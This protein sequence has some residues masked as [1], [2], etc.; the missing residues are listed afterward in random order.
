M[1][2]DMDSEPSTA[3]AQSSYFSGCMASPAW[4]PQ[5]VRRSPARFQLLARGGGGDDAAGRGGRRA[6]RGLLRRLVR[7]SKSICSNACRAPAAAA[8]FKYDADSYAKNFD[9]GRWHPCA[10][11]HALSP[12]QSRR[13]VDQSTRES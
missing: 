3:T 8:T 1:A 4:L 7:E 10:V 12:L 6:W 5:G 9:S 2:L 11:G 13:P